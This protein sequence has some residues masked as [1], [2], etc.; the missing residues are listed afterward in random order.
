MEHELILLRTIEFRTTRCPHSDI[1]LCPVPYLTCRRGA[2]GGSADMDGS[3][4]ALALPL[5]FSS[6][7]TSRS[8]QSGTRWLVCPI[9][10]SFSHGFPMFFLCVCF[11]I[12]TMPFSL[13][14]VP[15]RVR[16]VLRRVREFEHRVGLRE[17]RDHAVRGVRDCP[18]GA[19]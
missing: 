9:W 13:S 10:R 12:V 18:Q 11:L 7:P 14:L 8:L 4:P 16:V 6:S 19:G 5:C 1:D 3:A 2:T 17:H 15:T